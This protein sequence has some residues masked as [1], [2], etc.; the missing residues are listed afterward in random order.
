MHSKMI[1][2]KGDLL[3]NIYGCPYCY[4]EHPKYKG[5]PK[6]YNKFCPRCK[7][8]VQPSDILIAR[9]FEKPDKTHVHVLG[10]H[11]CRKER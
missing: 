11:Q 8:D 9:V 4:P 3:M 2:N 6:P 7:R 10:C 1:E 5:G